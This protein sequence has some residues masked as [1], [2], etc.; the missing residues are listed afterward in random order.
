[1][2][3]AGQPPEQLGVGGTAQVCDNNGN[4][5]GDGTFTYVYDAFNRIVSA[6]RKADTLLVAVYKYDAL[7]RRTEIRGRARK[8]LDEAR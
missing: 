5:T 2:V 4:L 3:F 8:F 6:T 1:M 7:G